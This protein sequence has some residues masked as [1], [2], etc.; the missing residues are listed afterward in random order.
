MAPIW[1][2]VSNRFES[3]YLAHQEYEI[4]E[5]NLGS[6]FNYAELV[7]LICPRPFMV[8][9]FL[10]SGLHEEHSAAEYGRVRLLY[11]NL[12]IG[13]R[14]RWTYFGTFRAGVPSARRETFDFLQE[15][16]RWPQRK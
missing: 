13:D 6:T 14:T 8:E 16:L 12:A 4:F 11:H 9:D 2:T 7:A 5:F 3:G 1:R 10:H 15:Q